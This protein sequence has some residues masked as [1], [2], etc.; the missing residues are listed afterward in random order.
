MSPETRDPRLNKVIEED[1]SESENAKE[2][3]DFLTEFIQLKKVETRKSY[4]PFKSYR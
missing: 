3:N 1:S 2:N 4:E